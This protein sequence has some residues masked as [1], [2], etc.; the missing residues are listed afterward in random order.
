MT[1]LQIKIKKLNSCFICFEKQFQSSQISPLGPPEFLLKLIASDDISLVDGRYRYRTYLPV[2]T[3]IDNKKRE[4]DYSNHLP[5]SQKI[6]Y[7]VWHGTK[8]GW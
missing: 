4:I 1:N 7:V 3:Y 2:P 5:I 6:R 8:L